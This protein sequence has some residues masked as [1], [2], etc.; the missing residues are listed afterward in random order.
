MLFQQDKVNQCILS[1]LVFAHNVC[2]VL[3]MII[4]H[5][6]TFTR[7]KFSP[8]NFVWVPRTISTIYGHSPL[9]INVRRT[10]SSS[11]ECPRTLSTGGHYPLL[12]ICLAANYPV[13]H[14]MPYQP[15]R[16][17]PVTWGSLHCIHVGLRTLKRSASDM[18]FYMYTC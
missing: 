8:V 15:L 9:V 6:I 3:F 13:L 7:T 18:Q 1:R 5:V 11:G 14:L 2:P 10:L 17:Q 12:H 4:L 16:R